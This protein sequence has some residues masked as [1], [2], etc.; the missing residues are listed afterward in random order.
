MKR[1][2][3]ETVQRILDAADIVEV[4]SDF[5]T[6]KKRGANYIGLCPF[7]N[8]RT[9][10]FSVSKSKGICKCFSCGKGGSPVGFIM[11]HEQMNFNEALRYLAKKYN[12][13]IREHEVS[14]AEKEKASEREAMIA[15][16]EFAL[17]HFEHNIMDTP[18][19]RDI[20]LAYFRERG[21]SD[22]MIKNFRLGYA[23]EKPDDLLNA[24]LA[25]GYSEK[26]LL[27]T[28]LC[29]RT[30]RGT[31]YDKF[32]GR[33]IYPILS[34]SGRAVGFGARTLRKDKNVAKYMNS[35]ESE[36][37][38]KSFELYGMYQAKNAIAKADKCILV[39]GY[40]DVISMHQA[41]VN[42]V[43][44]SSGTSLTDGQAR[45]IHRFTG[46]ATVIYDAD[47]AGIKAS[48][49]AIDILL[50]EGM[51][52]KLCLLPD[53][54]DPDSFAHSNSAS[55]VEEYIA[56]NE[57]DFVTFKSQIMLKDAGDDPI[58]RAA[59]ISD[60]IKSLALIVDPVKR[61][62]FMTHTARMFDIDERVL[63]LQVAKNIAENAEKAVKRPLQQAPA[64][65]TAEAAPA[66]GA[67]AP[68]V[69]QTP[70]KAAKAE[71]RVR[72]AE[73]PLI[74]YVIKY[75][76]LTLGQDLNDNELTE[77]TVIDC[78]RS[79]FENDEL[80]FSDPVARKI[81]NQALD[82]YTNQWPEQRQQKLAQIKA[83]KE[84]AMAEGHD[85]IRREAKDLAEIEV[86][87][88]QLVEETDRNCAAAFEE[89]SCRF[90]EDAFLSDP[91]DDVRRLATEL[92]AEKY[93]LSKMHTKYAHV[94][95]ERER[96][97]DLVQRGLYELKFVILEENI[98]ILNSRL[99][100]KNID[101]EKM[102]EMMT[103]LY[104]M[105]TLKSQLAKML[106]DRIVNPR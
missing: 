63:S 34:V 35:P 78:I 79:D 42:N 62:V 30:D 61:T 1:I 101:S 68:A 67:V 33:V 25:K 86:M 13:E 82:I 48:L 40:M 102:Q 103:E 11:E 60:I 24:A 81:Y 4:V 9:P 43:V 45:L 10:S 29:A 38:H 83:D 56:A 21:I 14:D 73:L 12:I 89:F 77:L 6:L 75:G 99:K 54:E 80:E 76:L 44:A 96:I 15:I 90:L 28:G 37:Y 52:I 22:A 93:Q 87:E 106:G 18:D 32:K 64:E 41:G 57:V 46:N 72:Q 36:I 39:E 65:T 105:Y 7:H 53:G 69:Q 2:D 104:E 95:T 20:G 70:T 16:N 58:K 23:L 55:Q 17:T 31:V 51:D 98:E 26:Y 84:R 88:Q 91:E 49:R 74:K 97:G 85:R 66:D 3:R 92:V 59:V 47:A 71:N 100:D 8:E 19:G 5:V 94:E 50:A 27:E